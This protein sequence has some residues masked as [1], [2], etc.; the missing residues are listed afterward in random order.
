[1]VSHRK[2]LCNPSQLAKLVVGMATG[3]VKDRPPKSF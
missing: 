1:M 2:P 3:T